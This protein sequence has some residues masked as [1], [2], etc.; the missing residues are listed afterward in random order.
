M[1]HKITR[2]LLIAGIPVLIASTAVAGFFLRPLPADLDFS[3]SRSTENAMYVASISPAEEPVTVGRMHAWTLELTTADGEPVQEADIAIDG[4]MP[5]HGH[6]LPTSPTVTRNLGGGRF[7]IEG[8]RFNMAGWW[9]L[10]FD[11]AG[12]VGRDHVTF[13]IVL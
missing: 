7:L 3:R 11:I 2:R 6:G 10:R 12:P 4:G 13:N 8:M 5:Q 1:T 9:E